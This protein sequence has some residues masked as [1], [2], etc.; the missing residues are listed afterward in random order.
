[1]HIANP[2]TEEFQRLEVA[3]WTGLGQ[4]QPAEVERDCTE[5]ARVGHRALVVDDRLSIAGHVDVV[6]FRALAGIVGP[7]AGFGKGMKLPIAGDQRRDRVA[8]RLQC[9]I[10]GDLADDP[11]TLLT[12]G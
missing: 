11:V 9:F 7:D 12:P 2:V 8:R 4:L 10:E 1:M 5:H 6:L 3:G